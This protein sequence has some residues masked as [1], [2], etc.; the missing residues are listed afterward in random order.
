[1]KCFPPKMECGCLHGGVIENGRTPNPLIL[2]T[3]PVLVHVRVW[4]HILGNPQ[5][6]HLRNV[7]TAEV[8][9]SVGRSRLHSHKIIKQMIVVASFN[10]NKKEQG[11]GPDLAFVVRWTL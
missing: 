7:T 9:L 3:V 4:G 11:G 6:V 5:S 1:M 8:L 10:N 2:W